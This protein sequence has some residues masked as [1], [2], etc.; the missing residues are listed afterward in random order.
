[1]TKIK[2]GK[3]FLIAQVVLAGLGVLMMLM[4][5]GLFDSI[6]A[7]IKDLLVEA[8][9]NVGDISNPLSYLISNIDTLESVEIMDSSDLSSLELPSLMV[10]YAS[11]LFVK[12][13]LST[14][15]GTMIIGLVLVIIALV[16]ACKATSKKALVAPMVLSFVSVLFIGLLSL[17]PGI[18]FA[19]V[20]DEDF[21]YVD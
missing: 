20:H 8:G 21:K 11:L 3:G 17:V 5:V 14:G 6:E 10:I 1:M 13:I 15:L 16:L 9:G 2:V 4:I 18:L 12:E 7:L 19:C